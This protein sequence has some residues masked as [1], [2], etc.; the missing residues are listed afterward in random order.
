MCWQLASISTHSLSW[1][2]VGFCNCTG[3]LVERAASNAAQQSMQRCPWWMH[4]QMRFLS[5]PVKEGVPGILDDS[6]TLPN[7]SHTLKTELLAP[8]W[9]FVVNLTGWSTQMTIQYNYSQYVSVSSFDLGQ[10][11]LRFATK[12]RAFGASHICSAPYH[13]CWTFHLL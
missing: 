6:I 13:R 3:R 7:N 5:I 4:G 2:G 11:S 1:V 12:H 8:M 10:I 9:N